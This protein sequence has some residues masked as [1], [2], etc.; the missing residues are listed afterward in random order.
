[1]KRKRRERRC[2]SRS[3]A[4][5]SR[6]C[7]RTLRYRSCCAP[8]SYGRK[9]AVAAAAVQRAPLHL[10]RQIRRRRFRG[11]TH[12][13]PHIPLPALLHAA[14]RRHLAACP[15][16]RAVAGGVLSARPAGRGPVRS[17]LDGGGGR[18]RA[19]R[20]C[21]RRCAAGGRRRRQASQRGGG[22]GRGQAAARPALTAECARRGPDRAA[23][24]SSWTGRTVLRNRRRRLLP[25]ADHADS[26][27][28]LI[29]RGRAPALLRIGCATAA[30]VWLKPGQVGSGLTESRGCSHQIEIIC[31][32]QLLPSVGDL[33]LC[34]RLPDP[35]AVVGK[36]TI[37]VSNRRFHESVVVLCAARCE[38]LAPRSLGVEGLL[39]R[40][41]ERSGSS[42]WA[43]VL[44]SAELAEGGSAARCRSLHRR[45]TV[46]FSLTQQVSKKVK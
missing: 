5:T 27:G 2:A 46:F 19:R 45:R 4:T 38:R 42:N 29:L 18:S 20:R 11:A 12:R 34:Q 36:A 8:L 32:L 39:R 33:V 26:A 44:P 21:R 37:F 40:H 15:R 13:R 31:S 7:C 30:E 9:A 17:R 22:S 23:R 6:V 3:I 41:S 35:C 16:R 14:R 25:A 1:M 24:R 28:R 43:A 10:G